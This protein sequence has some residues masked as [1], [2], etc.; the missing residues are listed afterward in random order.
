MAKQRPNTPA[1][2]A[3]ALQ[4]FQHAPSTRSLGI[5]VR[6]EAERGTRPLSGRQRAVCWESSHPTPPGMAKRED[7]IS[8]SPDRRLPRPETHL[9]GLLLRHARST[10][11]RP[12]E[13]ESKGQRGGAGRAGEGSR[14][15]AGSGSGC[16]KLPAARAEEGWRAARSAAF[17]S[18]CGLDFA[19]GA[20]VGPA[21]RHSW[22]AD[23]PCL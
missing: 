8:E 9:R 21:A 6:Q 22:I 18:V 17:G 2:A 13:R 5:R 14:T 20:S 3:E 19:P 23:L 7:A 10:P 16:Q 1:K 12:Q 4:Y 11:P 15:T